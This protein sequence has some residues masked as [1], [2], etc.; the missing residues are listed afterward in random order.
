MHEHEGGFMP[1]EPAGEQNF[2]RVPGSERAP[3]SG[4]RRVGDA[5]PDDHVLVTVVLR[6]DVDVPAAVATVADY[7]RGHG[8]EVEVADPPRRN[9][10][11]RGTVTQASAAFGVSL[12]QYSTEHVTYRGRE[13][14]VHLPAALAPL[15]QAVLG[16]DNRPQARIELHRGAS[17]APEALPHPLSH[18]PTHPTHIEPAAAHS[19]K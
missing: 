13:G 5:S 2:D 8:M 3:L 12:G 6:R 9:V 15:V 18:L 14:A 19:D 10:T 4:A 11:A 1:S 17:L 7:L 16:L